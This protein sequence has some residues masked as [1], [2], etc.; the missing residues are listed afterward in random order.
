MAIGK[1]PSQGSKNPSAGLPVAK[2]PPEVAFSKRSPPGCYGPGRHTE[3]K[4]RDE[5]HGAED[6]A[7]QVVGPLRAHEFGVM[8][9][10]EERTPDQD[11]PEH[12]YQ[13]NEERDPESPRKPA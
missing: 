12:Q 8:A 9:E 2:R 10:R 5:T 11:A 3:E 6:V 7:E 1:G 4:R 13:G